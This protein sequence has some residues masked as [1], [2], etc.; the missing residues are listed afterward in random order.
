MGSQPGWLATT[1]DEGCSRA[2]RLDFSSNFFPHFACK[3]CLLTKWR[4]P[5]MDIEHSQV[6]A[7]RNVLTGRAFY[8][9]FDDDCVLKKYG[10]RKKKTLL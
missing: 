1:R 3:G 7:K 5:R 4:D 2:D 8:I 10:K 6:K 9:D